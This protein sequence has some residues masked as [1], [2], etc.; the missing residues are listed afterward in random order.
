MKK[1]ELSVILLTIC[2]VA[3]IVPYMAYAEEVPY[4]PWVDEI[5]FESGFEEAI[6]FDKMKKGEMHL[7]IKDWTDVELL[8]RIK[9]TPELQYD[10]SF[11][12]FYE[13]TFNPVGPTF[14][15]TGGFNPFSNPKIREAMNMLVDRNYIVDELMKGLAKPKLLPIVSA[16]PDYGRLAE[17]AVLLES[18]YKNDPDKAEEIIFEELEEMGAENVGGKWYYDGEIVTLKMLIRTEDQRKEIGDYVSDLL[19]DLGFE[20]DRMYRTSAEASPIWLFGDPA[21]GEFH[22]YTGGWISTVISRDDADNFAYYYTDMGLPFP[23]YMAYENDPTFY[24]AARKLDAGDWTTWE[25]RMELMRKCAFLA[26]EDSARVFLV[27]QLAPFVSRKDTEVAFDLSGAFS[28]QIWALTIKLKDQVGGVLTAGSA[29]ILVQPWNPEAGT[30]WLYDSIILDTTR[31]RFAHVYNPYTG[32]PMPLRM[33]SV[34]MEVERGVPTSSSSDWLSISYVDKVEVPTDA[35]YDW[36]VENKEVITAPPGTTVKCKVVVNFGDCIGEVKYHD[37][38]VMSM[39]DWIVPWVIDFEQA[40]PD[41]SIY[42]ESSLPEFESEMGQM[43]GMRIVSEKPLIIEYYTD[44]LTREAE[45]IYE[46]AVDRIGINNEKYPQLPWQA[47]AIGI[48]AEEEGLLAFSADKAEEL[49]IE[50]M[51]YLGGPSKAILADM[52]DEAIATGYIPFEELVGDYLTSEE[53]STRYQNLKNFYDDKGHFWV[54]SGNFYLDQVDF[55]GHSAVV[56]AFKDY[57]FKADRFSRLAEP[58]IPD[59]AVVVPENIIPGLG[60]VI[61]YDLT[62]KGDP[63]PNDKI[64]L[65]KYMILD[66]VGNLITVGESEP[67]A[68]GKW[69]IGLDSTETARMSAGS[70][71]LITIALSK[72]VA[73]PGVLETPFLVMPDVLSYLTAIMTEQE[74]ELDAEIEGLQ[75][76]LS[77]TQQTVAELRDTV[78]ALEIPT[79]LVGRIKS[80]QTTT[81]AAIAV[82]IIAILLAV[83]PILTKK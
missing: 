45:F 72:D 30:N 31:E 67:V 66:S 46:F 36:D 54:G 8:E 74:A 27:D 11:G 71:E 25:E 65:A 73:M 42:D 13:L 21:D 5:R 70:Y 39:A 48:K 40:D 29:E 56:K 76:T 12:L 38:S 24:E 18:K 60:A 49:N 83:Y 75:S 68:E 22:I 19:E 32:L 9:V 51:N 57:T 14:P 20:T 64:E 6:L 10:T 28:N 26:L 77:D 3:A 81:Y 58:P 23:L 16:F 33:E 1:Q 53:V 2:L 55:V 15:K 63:Y 47:M 34:T 52:L 43:K 7:Y 61:N 82:A 59:S 50:W 62:Y 80:L 44:Y 37:G 78:E 41:S 35:W 79:E 17:T 69:L 4:G